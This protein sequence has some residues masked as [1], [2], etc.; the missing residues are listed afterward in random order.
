MFS[1]CLS[2]YW[3]PNFFI[4]ANLGIAANS[5]AGYSAHEVERYTEQEK[6]RDI[7]EL[8]R[9]NNFDTLSEHDKY[10]VLKNGFVPEANFDFP[11]TIKHG[12][13]CSFKTDYLSDFFVYSCQDN[14]VYCI[15]SV[16][17]VPKDRCII[18]GAFVN[19]GYCE[20]HNIMEKEKKHSQNTYHQEAVTLALV[21][22]HRFKKPE[23]TIRALI[24]N[25]I[26]ERYETY[27]KIVDVISRVIH[28][29]GK[30][31]IA[32]RGHRQE[33]DDSKPDDNPGNFLYIL[34]EV[35]H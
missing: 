25:S 10:I 29:I 18:L 31:G 6:P 27:P 8:V 9:D 3:I 11:K 2:L 26:K 32:L 14:A 16:L 21:T 15:Y 5:E 19:R 30:Q 35:A 20:C 24:D 23:S 34:T 33:L 1:F 7:V 13:N 22:I 4:S 17:F 28:L 12:C